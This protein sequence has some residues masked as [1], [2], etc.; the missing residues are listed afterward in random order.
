MGFLGDLLG[1]IGKAGSF[2]DIIKQ[3][4]DLVKNAGLGDV[5]ISLA[6]IKD[7]EKGDEVK[8]ALVLENVADDI[9]NLGVTVARLLGRE[10]TDIELCDEAE[11]KRYKRREEA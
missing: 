9:E 7:C 4:E 8:L 5:R 2:A 3:V 1:G 10:V 11:E 6:L